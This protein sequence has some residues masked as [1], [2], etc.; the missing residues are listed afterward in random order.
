MVQPDPRFPPP[1]PHE[2]DPTP[3]AGDDTVTEPIDVVETE[4][5][6]EMRGP[7]LLGSRSFFRLWMAQV[8]SSLGDWTGLVAVLAIAARVGGSSPEAAIG[9]VMSARLIPGFF[10]ASVGGVL[11]DR[12]DR[13]KV[14]VYCDI[15]RGLVMATLPF[16]ESVAGLFLAS[17]LL[18]VLTLLW[19]PAKEA[20][21]PNLVPARKLTTANSLSLAAAYGT[22]P[23]GSALF[24]S[25]TKVAEFLGDNAGFLN[26]LKLNQESLAIYADVITFFISAFLISTLAIPRR[27]PAESRDPV[28]G[29]GEAAR[30]FSRTV[31][32]VKEGWQ[33]IRTSPV[34]RSVMVG[35]GTGLIGG[36]MVAPLGPTFSTRVLHAGPAGFGLLL[37]A[38]GMGVA[39][40][41]VGLSTVQRRLPQD[42]IFPLAVL[43]AGASMMVAV[44]MSSLGPTMLFIGLMGICAGA[45]YVLGFTI[46]QESVDDELRGRIFATLYTLSRLCLLVSLTLAPLVAGALDG[47]SESLFGGSL[48]FGSFTVSLPGVRLTLWLGASIILFAGVLALRSLRAAR[49][50]AG[51]RAF[52]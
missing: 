24:A 14:M 52:S 27:H 5:D 37:T 41:V 50:E 10:L 48:S 22:F 44:S 3:V 17:L 39:V 36:G 13:K 35:L 45:V 15:G 20:T 23:L 30:A 47:I 42:L 33:F 25:L 26:F 11:V 16:V 18:E 49:D 40:G 1:E 2:P 8:A 38:L 31:E 51:G 4:R 28:D 12:W 21:V 43:G 9:I 19:S 32:E 7:S 46:L 29:E 6:P 34:V